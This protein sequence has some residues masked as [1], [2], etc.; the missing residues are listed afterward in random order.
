MGKI[1]YVTYIRCP[2][3]AMGQHRQVESDAHDGKLGELADGALRDYKAG[4]AVG[5]VIPRFPLESPQRFGRNSD[6]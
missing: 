3:L 1:S 5:L 6:A 2:D 4:W